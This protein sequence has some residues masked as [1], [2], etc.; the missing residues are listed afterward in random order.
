MV[1]SFE[2]I[3]GKVVSKKLKPHYILTRLVIPCNADGTELWLMVEMPLFVLSLKLSIRDDYR[4]R[5]ITV[6]L[7]D[8]HRLIL[9]IF[10]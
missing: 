4:N 10:F 2:K 8:N 6:F 1:D 3:G 5:F 7:C 9:S